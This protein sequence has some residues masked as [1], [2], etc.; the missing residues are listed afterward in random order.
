VSKHDDDGDRAE[1]DRVSEAKGDHMTKA[2]LLRPCTFAH[3]GPC[4]DDEDSILELQHFPPLM[5]YFG[6]P[7]FSKQLRDDWHS[8]AQGDTLHAEILTVVLRAVADLLHIE[9]RAAEESG[10]DR[11]AEALE[12]AQ[13]ET[14]S[15]MGALDRAVH[16]QYEE[17]REEREGDAPGKPEPA[18]PVG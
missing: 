4:P 10:Y 15:T 16:A 1:G 17:T 6:G 18:V 5:L 14:R 9:N 7:I 8:I 13:E 3:P 11:L 2:E 12:Q